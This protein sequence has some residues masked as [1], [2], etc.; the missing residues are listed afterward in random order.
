M[1]LNY[2]SPPQRNSYKKKYK[3]IDHVATLK[4]N[5]DRWAKVAEFKISQTAYGTANHY[6]RYFPG[7]ETACRKLPN[8]NTGVWFRWPSNVEVVD[9]P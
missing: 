9:G 7:L 1:R 6:K 8:G 3:Y 5:P 2:S 4:K